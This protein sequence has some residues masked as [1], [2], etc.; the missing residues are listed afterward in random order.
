M[1]IVKAQ[2]TILQCGKLIDPKSGKISSNVSIII[3]GNKI[4]E[5]KDGFATGNEGVTL[6]IDVSSTFK[7]GLPSL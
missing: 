3:E 5:V 4:V 1:F 7:K 2:Q 6:L